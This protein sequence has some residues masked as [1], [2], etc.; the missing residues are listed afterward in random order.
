MSIQKFLILSAYSLLVW[1]NI[2]P[3]PW[4]TL[5]A[6]DQV[7]EEV[8]VDEL[9]LLEEEEEPDTFNGIPDAG[10]T[11]NS[12]E[13]MQEASEVDEEDSIVSLVESITEDDLIIP[14][15]FNIDDTLQESDTF[16]QTTDVT[17]ETESKEE[18]TSADPF[19]ELFATSTAD[20]SATSE[21]GEEEPTETESETSTAVEDESA[22]EAVTEDSSSEE[23]VTEPEIEEEPEPQTT[24]LERKKRDIRVQFSY[25]QE[26]LVTILNSYAQKRNINV[27]LP[28]GA[29][30]IKQ[31]VSFK[32]D[33]PISLDEADAYIHSILDLAGYVMLEQQDFFVVRPKNALKE[34]HFPH[35]LYFDIPPDALPKSEEIIHGIYT[36]QNIEIP[37]S[38]TSSPLYKILVEMIPGG[39]KSFTI[40]PKTR[41]LTIVAPAATIASVMYLLEAIEQY[42]EK[43]I[44]DIHPLFFTSAS[45]VVTLMNTLIPK[46]VNTRSN[47]KGSLSTDSS[48]YFTPG[49][50]VISNAD[51]NAVLILGRENSVNK[52][53]KFITD[54]IDV[55]PDT[56]SSVFH[57]YDLQYLDSEKFAEDLRKVVE[58]R[59]GGSQSTKSKG[60]GPYAFF[61]EPIIIAQTLRQDKSGGLQGTSIGGNR[62]I[63][64]ATKR[65]WTILKELIQQLD[66]PQKQIIIEVLIADLTID[67]NKILSS[68]FRPP[69]FMNLPD[70]M[71]FQAAHIV[72][73]ILDP[74]NQTLNSDL[75]RI[76]Q[77]GTASIARPQTSQNFNGSLIFSFTDPN[78]TN[79][80][81]IVGK[82]LDKLAES[83]VVS[84]PFL[85]TK[86]NVKATANSKE[87]RRA[88]GNVY[89]ANNNVTTQKIADFTAELSVSVLPRTSSL[90]RVNLEVD[91]QIEDFVQPGE[92]TNFTRRNRSLK[93]SVNMDSGDVLFI[94]GLQRLRDN[95]ARTATPLLA[96]I[97]IIGNLFRGNDSNV[98]DGYLAVLICPTI[99]DPKLAI[100]QAVYN[101]DK[102]NAINSSFEEDDIAIGDNRD[103]ITRWYFN[104]DASDNL[105]LYG[106]LDDINYEAL[107]DELKEKTDKELKGESV[108]LALETI[109]NPFSLERVKEENTPP[110]MAQ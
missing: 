85:V 88:K 51:D 10:N 3:L 60:Q 52:V 61:D 87:I 58:G 89:A 23:E 8:D 76:I 62:L 7:V 93:T 79:G 70:G 11:F 4:Q 32:L 12:I 97:P 38:F 14:R 75:L 45:D 104:R 65:D 49:T 86:N 16:V 57:T 24:L 50:R 48:Y 99:V 25:D 13:S 81:A 34:A 55:A 6:S 17:P 41:R 102:I 36:L 37:E 107:Y 39:D 56:G 80:I 94:G 27:I 42:G 63:V 40:E 26:E 30:A 109:E 22:A 44:L 82:I 77:G 2:A 84:N 5:R 68:Q 64:A 74:A 106:Y 90:S 31:K 28:Q 78:R 73:P 1:V 15:D 108:R 59:S 100:G 43:D 96:S 67:T 72:G 19:A 33:R 71:Q 46:T 29:D 98:T 69:D 101:D 9:D 54:F 66:R 105:A 103:P 95:E 35:D 110:F 91:I 21:E 83:K 20:D 18:N 53:R 47:L 92:L